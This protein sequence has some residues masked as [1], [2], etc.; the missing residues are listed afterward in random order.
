[1]E[2]NSSMNQSKEEPM[3]T[4]TATTN[5]STIDIPD[6]FLYTTL[7]QNQTKDLRKAT[8]NREERK[9][10]ASIFN[11]QAIRR[12]PTEE[13]NKV[14][15]IILDFHYVNYNFCTSNQ[16]SNEKVSTLMAIMDFMLHTMIKKQMLVEDG[17]KLFKQ[18]LDKHSRQRPPFQIFIFTAAEI[19]MIINF[20]LQSFFRHYILYEYSFKPKV[21]LV[22]M[23]MPLRGGETGRN[24]GEESMQQESVGMEGMDIDMD[25]SVGGA[26]SL[27]KSDMNASK[28]G[29]TPDLD[30]KGDPIDWDKV[31]RIYKPTSAITDIISNE[32]GRL[33]NAFDVNSEAQLENH[34]DKMKTKKK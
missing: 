29:K 2:N 7:N 13:V 14:D 11:L 27:Q 12:S 22:L 21:E 15:Q 34:E 19:T 33:R 17:I 16:F 28:D 30:S 8:S 5:R 23:T 31:G 24:T 32:V 10:L 18:I 26:P 4:N 1:M 6:F 3:M 9:I 25:A 20:M